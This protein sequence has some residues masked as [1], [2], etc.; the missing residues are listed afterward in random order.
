MPEHGFIVCKVLLTSTS[1]KT[2]MRSYNASVSL[3]NSSLHMDHV[4]RQIS[5]CSSITT[6]VGGGKPESCGEA[7]WTYAEMLSAK[8]PAHG[9]SLPKRRPSW[10]CLRGGWSA[11]HTVLKLTSAR[12]RLRRSSEHCCL[13]K[14]WT[15]SSVLQSP[16]SS[17]HRHV[18]LPAQLGC[19]QFCNN[20]AWH[21]PDA[22]NWKNPKTSYAKYCL[23]S[24]LAAARHCLRWE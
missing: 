13:P 19:T 5:H 15:S 3:P 18:R 4:E 24:L 2:E 1:A 22:L 10:K 16:A 7:S 11:C 14:S 20:V 9:L 6:Y 12:H 8:Q 17:A 21:V 23:T